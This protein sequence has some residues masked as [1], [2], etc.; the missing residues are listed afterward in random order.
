MEISEFWRCHDIIFSNKQKMLSGRNFLMNRLLIYIIALCFLTACSGESDRS[1]VNQ[2]NTSV[3][4]RNSFTDEEKSYGYSDYS[5]DEEYI[6]VDG[7]DEP[8][9][10]S[11]FDN[12]VKETDDTIAELPQD[13]QNFIESLQ[14]GEVYEL[15]GID[16]PLTD[17]DIND[18]LLSALNGEEIAVIVSEYQ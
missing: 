7:F 13:Y 10:Q 5:E 12:I 9:T 16:K 15:Y 6:C 18:M 2:I 3:E 1:D 17:E 14:T 8:M 11:E 4:S